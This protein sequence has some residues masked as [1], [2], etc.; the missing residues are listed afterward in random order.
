MKHLV[1]ALKYCHNRSLIHSDVKPAN[2]LSLGCLINLFHVFPFFMNF[3]F[4]SML[5]FELNFTKMFM[6]LSKKLTGLRLTDPSPSA[7]LKL[8][9]FGIAFQV[10]TRSLAGTPAYV[11]L[12]VWTGE[13]PRDK[14]LDCYA[15]AAVLCEMVEGGVMVDDEA[16]TPRP[17]PKLK[18]QAEEGCDLESPVFLHGSSS[19]CCTTSRTI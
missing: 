19:R 4:S 1:S 6:F 15:A 3:D 7:F 8:A 10:M 17:S 12:E 18:S 2:L 14:Y 16:E 11:P 9:D 13:L 5:A